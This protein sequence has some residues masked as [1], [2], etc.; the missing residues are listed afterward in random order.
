MGLQERKYIVME[1]IVFPY[2]NLLW[3]GCLV[4]ILEILMAIRQRF[5]KLH[6][7]KELA[8]H[9]KENTKEMKK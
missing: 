2:I 7:Q 9:T 8:Y 4:M 3:T 6:L 5:S 1:A